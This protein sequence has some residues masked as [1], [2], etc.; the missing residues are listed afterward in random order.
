MSN[1]KRSE[2]LRHRKTKGLYGRTIC[3]R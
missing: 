1:E 3:V 2:N